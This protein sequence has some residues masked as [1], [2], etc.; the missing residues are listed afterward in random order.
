MI[1]CWKICPRIGTLVVDRQNY[2]IRAQSVYSTTDEIA[3]TI[4]TNSDNQVVRVRDVGE[5]ID[6]FMDVTTLE[7]G[8][9][10]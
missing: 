10:S 8:A 4:I 3:Q 6:S 7:E 5:V 2:S 9:P 1:N